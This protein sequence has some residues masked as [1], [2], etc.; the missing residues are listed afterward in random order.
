M[1]NYIFLNCNNS[2]LRE[3]L[4]SLVC[5]CGKYETTASTRLAYHSVST[6]KQWMSEVSSPLGC[7]ATKRDARKLPCHEI[8]CFMSPFQNQNMKFL[9]IDFCTSYTM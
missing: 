3:T 7:Q 8:T 6:N 2:T 5:L 9:H 1:Q 4:Y